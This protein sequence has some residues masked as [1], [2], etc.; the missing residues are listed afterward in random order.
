MKNVKHAFP[1]DTPF[2]SFYWNFTSILNSVA[3]CVAEMAQALVRTA[4]VRGSA[5]PVPPVLLHRQELSQ[6]QGPDRPGS[7]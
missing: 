6:A 1:L 7:V 3:Y 5:G 2:Y 4:P